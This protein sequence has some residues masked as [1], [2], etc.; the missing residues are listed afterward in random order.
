M[1][2]INFIHYLSSIT[3]TE[4]SF[5][6]DLST[7][8]DRNRLNEETQNS[9]I[10]K[11][12]KMR[13]ISTGSGLTKL[14]KLINLRRSTLNQV[15]DIL[16]INPRG[17]VVLGGDVLSEYYAGRRIAIDLYKL[18]RLLRESSVFLVSQTIGPFHS[19]RKHL[20]RFCLRGCQ[21]YSRDVLSAKYLRDTL[22]LKNV[23]ETSDLA[24]LDLPKQ[25]DDKRS[26]NLLKR[27]DIHRDEYIT[28]VPSGSV[29]QYT[30]S[31][32]DYLKIWSN[33]TSSLF[34]SSNLESKKIILLPHVL[35]PTHADDRNII[36]DIRKSLTKKYAN[37]IC[38]RDVLLPSEARIILGNGLFTITG[39]MHAAISTFQMLKPAISLSYSLKY[40]GIVGGGLGLNDLIIEARGNELWSTGKIV[41]EVKDRIE[42][43]LLNYDDL[44]SG[45]RPAVKKNKQMAIAQIEDVARKI[46][47]VK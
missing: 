36:E 25:N 6:A 46:Q 24:F 11:Q 2:A 23:F 1:L 8:D 5:I 15:K 42:Y 21:I 38:I 40:K 35:R 12:L 26:I 39:R 30:N 13:E 41:E 22:K 28:I 33:I 7:E 29:G 27:Y 34:E 44:I 43:V 17:I 32:S 20:A 16:S 19:W 3:D 10:I 31:Y 47:E 4:I 37:L 14:Q 45:I 18:H 9:H